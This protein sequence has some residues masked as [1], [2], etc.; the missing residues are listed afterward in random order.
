MEKYGEVLDLETIEAEELAVKMSKF[1]CEAKPKDTGKTSADYHKNS[2]KNIRCGINR[3]LSDIGRQIDIV[4]DKSFRK[5]N[6]TLNGLLKH[7]MQS[8]VSRPT[9]HKNVI[10]MSDLKKIA[11]YFDDAE[12][13]PIKLR[14]AV[15][16]NIA[17]HF[18]SRGLE[19]HHQLTSSSFEFI[20]DENGVEYAC[21]THETQQKT[22]RGV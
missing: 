12:S 13:S 5:P 2:L 7:R 8:G 1:Y 20:S 18:V 19:F 6:Q 4:H 10:E 17:V 3:Y 15:W 14:Q 16:F 21:L 11:K 9:K 22:F